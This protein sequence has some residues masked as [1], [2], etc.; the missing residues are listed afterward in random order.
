MTK[1]RYSER[2]IE[3]LIERFESKTLPKNEWTHQAHLVV[4][5]WFCTHYEK[6]T[7]LNLVRNHIIKHNESVGTPNTD[8]EGYH[9]TM[10]RF[11]LWVADQFLKSEEFVSVTEASNQFINSGFGAK[12]YPSIYYSKEVLFSLD[13][14]RG[15]VEPDLTGLRELVENKDQKVAKT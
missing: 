15:W 2:E 8:S 6:E 7:A 9:E 13:A 14:R 1:I 11:W 5:I 10:T 4:A 3:S 12:N